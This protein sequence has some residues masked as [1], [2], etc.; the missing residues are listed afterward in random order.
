MALTGTIPVVVANNNITHNVAGNTRMTADG[1]I[2]TSHQMK[3][4]RG[5]TYTIPDYT[6]TVPEGKAFAGW[7]VRS[8]GE[9]YEPG[10]TFYGHRYSGSTY[11]YFD[12]RFVD[13]SDTQALTRFAESHSGIVVMAYGG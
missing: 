13:T 2:L 12:P 5:Y 10:D 1:S 8:R 11:L 4:T 9:F 6:G 7:D 3:S